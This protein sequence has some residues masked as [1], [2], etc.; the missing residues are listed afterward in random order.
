VTTLGHDAAIFANDN[1]RFPGS[2][3]FRRL[4]IGGIQSVLGMEPFCL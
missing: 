3:E 2:V 4:L 1:Q